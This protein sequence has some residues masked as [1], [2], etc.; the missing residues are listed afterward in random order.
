MS[1]QCYRLS[2]FEC[3]WRSNVARIEEYTPPPDLPQIIHELRAQLSAKERECEA[4][5]AVIREL[6]EM[7]SYEQLQMHRSW[8]NLLTKALALIG[9]EKGEGR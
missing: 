6:V 8:R 9:G 4:R 7:A 5:D 3:V 2:C 1:C